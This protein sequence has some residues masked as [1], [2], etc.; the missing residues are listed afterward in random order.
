MPNH[1]PHQARIG[2]GPWIGTKLLWILAVGSGLNDQA[3]AQ[4]LDAARLLPS[5]SQRSTTVTIELP[6]K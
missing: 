6:G 5:G 2:V 1:Q 4:N 3:L